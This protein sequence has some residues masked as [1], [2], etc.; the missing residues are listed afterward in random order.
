MIRFDEAL[1]AGLD[2]IR[3]AMGGVPLGLHVVR[4]MSGSITWVWPEDEPL[5]E[6]RFASLRIA[7]HASIGDWSAGPEQVLIQQC[8]LIDSDDIFNSSD[9]RK[10]R[11]SR[12]DGTGTDVLWVVDRLVTNQEW[13]REP[14]PLIDGVRLCSAF[15]IKG[16]V[17]RTT[18]FAIWAWAMAREGK[19]VLL[20]DLDLE[21]PGIA[22]VLSSEVPAYGVTDWLVE[23]LAHE[24]DILLLEDCI[25]PWF[26]NPDLSGSVH[27]LPAFGSK[28]LSYIEKLGRVFVSS[29]DPDSG[30]SGFS[31]RLHRLLRAIQSTGNYDIVLIDSRAGLHDIG[32]CVV[33]RLWAEV[34]MFARDEVQSWAAYGQL[35]RHLRDSHAIRWNQQADDSDLRWRLKMVGAQT[36]PEETARTAFLRRSYDQWLDLYD[37]AGEA[38]SE[39]DLFSFAQDDAAAPHHPLMI[40]FDPQVRS[41]RLNSVDA[42]PAWELV[43]S[44]YGPFL[45]AATRRLFPNQAGHSSET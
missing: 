19:R 17:G 30:Y 6:A 36:A 21:A 25:Q 32:A 3:S 23:A 28:T 8:D 10:A 35:F 7:L 4:D 1:P 27:F 31:E 44:I 20:L 29:F 5:D 12:R 22:S 45:D 39:F 15:S 16:G 42:L 40:P 2:A 38:T 9:S 18:A 43:R 11:V 24:P 14:L 26:L 37:A 34:L 41:F 33:T 13:L